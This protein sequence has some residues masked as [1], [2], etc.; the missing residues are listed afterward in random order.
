VN[1]YVYA[2]NDPTNRTDPTGELPPE[3]REI[4]DCDQ[5][6]KDCTWKCRSCNKDQESCASCCWKRWEHCEENGSWP[7][8]AKDHTTCCSAMELCE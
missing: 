7:D 1:L 5:I 6:R 4:D 3:L 2:E 8:L